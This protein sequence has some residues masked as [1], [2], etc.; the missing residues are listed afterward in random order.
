MTDK[1]TDETGTRSLD[2]K[3]APVS[4]PAGSYD[5]AKLTGALEKAVTAPADKRD[6]RVQAALE[7]AIAGGADA[8][9][10]RDPAAQ[11]GF[12]TVE[13][14]HPTDAA[15]TETI[16]VFSPDQEKADEKAAT[17]ATPST[18]GAT[19]STAPAAGSSK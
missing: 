5:F 14:D 10:G 15:R 2:P 8:L 16:S 6:D 19:T 17:A 4:L 18:I 13:V 11:T 7:H 1:L 9:K 12:T 3:H